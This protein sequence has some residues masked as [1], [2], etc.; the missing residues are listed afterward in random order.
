M[1]F[2]E[3]LYG[4]KSKISERHRHRYEV[5]IDYKEKL[6]EKGLKFVGQ[7]P[8]GERMQILE[9]EGHDYFVATQFHPEY[10]SRYN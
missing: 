1:E 5:N 10:L 7:D 9:L 8:L 3:R 4:N 6:E 2:L